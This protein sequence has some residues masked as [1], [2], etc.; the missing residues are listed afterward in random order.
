[1][2]PKIYKLMF[3]FSISLFVLS[4]V[5]VGM[6]GLKL[7]VDFKGGSVLELNFN[8]RPDVAKIQSVLVSKIGDV[9]LNTEGTSGLIVRSHELTEIQHQEVLASLNSSFPTAGLQEKQFSSV[10]PIIGNELKQ[11]SLFAIALVLICVIVYI[12]FVFRKLG[13]TTSPWSMG[14]AAVIA[15]IHDVAIPVG[16]FAALGHFYGIEIT[17][18][19]VAAALT[20]LG[21][22]VSDTVVIFDRVRENVIRGGGKTNFGELVHRSVMQ[23]LTRSLNTVFTVLLSLFAIYFFGGASIKYFSLALIIGIFLGA[24]SSIFVASPLLVWWTKK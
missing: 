6:F 18:V 1:M 4:V 21:F 8:N 23:T 22:S 24:Y 17:G 12:A 5:S 19:F 14:L 20:I 3:W 2:L 16:V 15:L 11:R 7:G 13:R 9:E 10:G